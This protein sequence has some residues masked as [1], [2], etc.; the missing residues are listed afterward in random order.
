MSSRALTSR[1]ALLRAGSARDLGGGMRRTRRP[2]RA[3]EPAFAWNYQANLCS[4][5][6]PSGTDSIVIPSVA[7]DLGGGMRRTRRPRR[8]RE[9][10]FAWN[11]RANLGSCAAHGAG[12]TRSP[13]PDPSRSLP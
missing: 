13:H 9:P 7:R 5:A 12:V 10:S 3:R 2:R 11:Y 8:A 4:C 1:F 6:A